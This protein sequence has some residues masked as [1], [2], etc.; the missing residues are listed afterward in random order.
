[1][2]VPVTSLL[3]IVLKVT[4]VVFEE[5]NGSPG[6]Y[7]GRPPLH[8]GPSVFSSETLE[9]GGSNICIILNE[10]TRHPI[11]LQSILYNKGTIM[12]HY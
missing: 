4:F 3:L 5:D 9:R 12:N 8:P 6:G 11:N 10:M 1:M 7:T 2:L